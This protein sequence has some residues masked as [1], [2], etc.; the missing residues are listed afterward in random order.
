MK[1]DD[2]LEMAQIGVEALRGSG[3]SARYNVDAAGEM[4]PARSGS[5]DA[6]AMYSAG[7]KYAYTVELRDTGTHGYLL[8]PSYIEAAAKDTFELI[9]GMIDFI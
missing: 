7:I 1:S 2:L 5:V 4:F 9:K 8:P 6:F 3:T